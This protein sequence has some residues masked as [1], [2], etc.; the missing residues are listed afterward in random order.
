MLLNGGAGKDSWESLLYSKEIKPVHPK[1]NQSWIFIG[2]TDAEAEA[3]IL[4]PCD[5]K[6][7][8]IGKDPDAGKD[9]GQEVQG[10]TGWDGWIASL[11]QWTLVWANSREAWRATVHA[12]TKCQ[13]WLID[14]TETTTYLYNLKPSILKI[15]HIQESEH[16]KYT[17]QWNFI[18][19]A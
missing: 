8:L 19:R 3:P 6:S 9:W 4:W 5:M 17:A 12:V 1:G 7:Q 18:N 16:K 2:R 15:S 10:A 11:T 14:Q 13:I